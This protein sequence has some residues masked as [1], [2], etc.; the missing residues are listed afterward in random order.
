MSARAHSAGRLIALGFLL[1]ALA[2]ALHA[3]TRTPA[4]VEQMY[5]DLG[6]QMSCVCGGC[7]DKLL[8]CSHNNC[9]AKNIQWDYL[10]EL[11]QNPVNDAV[12]IKQAM[13]ARFGEKV[14][15]IP[16]DSNLFLVLV[17]AVGM[18]AGAFGVM[19]WYVA[20]RGGQPGAEVATNSTGRAVKD[21]LELRIERD[22]QELK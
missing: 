5:Q 17:L 16:E 7:R 19:F 3:Q 18:L 12:A 20:A 4:E 2:P 1:F 14:L 10:R 21:D 8:V 22:L 9:S 15:Q 13:V 11:C 6:G